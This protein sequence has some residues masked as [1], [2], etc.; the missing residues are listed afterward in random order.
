MR[1]FPIFLAALIAFAPSVTD[2]GTFQIDSVSY[3]TT[4][5]SDGTSTI[6][7]VR[8]TA[9]YVGEVDSNDNSWAL[10]TELIALGSVTD[11]VRPG[12]GVSAGLIIDNEPVTSYG[13]QRMIPDCKALKDEGNQY[14]GQ[15]IVA[16]YH[17]GADP[18]VDY[19]TGAWGRTECDSFTEEPEGE[20]G[21]G[22]EEGGTEPR[23]PGTD[24]G[25]PILIDLDR[26]G[27]TLTDLNNGVLFDLD[28]DGERNKLAWTAPDSGDGWLALDRNGNG[29]IDHGGE[30]FGNFT[31]QPEVGA[32]DGYRALAVF[33]DPAHGGDGNG[34]IDDRDSVYSQLRVWIDA[35]HD[36]ISQPAELLD[37][38]SAGVEWLETR[39][40]TSRRRDRH[41]N[42][43]RYQ[44]LVRLSVGMTSSVDVFLLGGP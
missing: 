26:G 41:G 13:A 17:Q 2:A 28:G 4:A 22:G 19:G 8:A 36:G 33:D 14:R 7:W 30:L 29:V 10:Q 40:I 44:A 25:S 23:P 18:E 5:S 6:V 3:R 16:I 43:L 31:E 42:E 11:N 24:A 32:P 37:L 27:F 21:S 9:R 20:E 1:W 12:S 35:N 38:R 39:P 34:I 15:A